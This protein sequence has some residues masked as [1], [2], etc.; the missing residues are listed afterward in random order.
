M[1]KFEDFRK[2]DIRICKVVLAEKVEGAD[3]LVRLQ[4]D[5]G[6]EKRQI[7]AGMAEFFEP[8]YFIGK[9]LVVVANLEPRKF[10]GF[11]SQGMIL[12]ADLNGKPVLLHPEKEIP[13]GTIVR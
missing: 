9:E 3:K 2:L 4:V 6:K 8:Q 1:I 13:P 12:A 7:I 11:E 5:L 10:M